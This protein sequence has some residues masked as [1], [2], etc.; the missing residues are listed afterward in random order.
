MILY[1]QDSL[2]AHIFSFKVF[3]LDAAENPLLCFAGDLPLGEQFR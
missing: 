1:D 3:F 2:S